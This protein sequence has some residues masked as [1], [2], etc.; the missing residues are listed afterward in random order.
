MEILPSPSWIK[1]ETKLV[2]IEAA[3]FDWYDLNRL[4]C[5]GVKILR[6]IKL[7]FLNSCFNK[8]VSTV[9]LFED[10]VKRIP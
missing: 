9:A 1:S 8:P 5:H 4:I 3:L 2:C 7:L 6:F 10:L